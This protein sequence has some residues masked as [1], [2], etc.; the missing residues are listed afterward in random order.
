MLPSQ[1]TA[2]ALL[3]LVRRGAQGG[4]KHGAPRPSV[5]LVLDLSELRGQPIDDVEDLLGRRIQLADGTLVPRSTAERLLCDADV[6]EIVTWLRANGM[7]DVVLTNHTSRH[8]NA[9]QRKVLAER[10]RGCVFPGCDKPVKWCDAHHLV[11]YELCQRTDL[12]NLV[13]LCRWHHHAV[14]EGGY[15]MTRGPDGTIHV[16]RPEGTLL[17]RARPGRQA[18]E[19]DPLHPDLHDPPTVD[20]PARPPSRFRTL[21]QR[22]DAHQRDLEAMAAEAQEG[23]DQLHAWAHAEG[24]VDHLE[25]VS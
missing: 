19:P 9:I 15:R 7:T 12:E 21:A 13:L 16:I 25:P 23:I 22:R 18:T 20:A 10:D 14:H 17:Q 1:R 3:N 2:A 24:L 6:T 4:T 11:P 8:A 5:S